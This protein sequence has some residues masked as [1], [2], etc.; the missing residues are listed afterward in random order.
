MT[1]GD[2]K[3]LAK[4]TASDN[5]LRDKAFNILKN[6]KHGGYQRGRNS[7]AYTFFDKKASCS[8]I[9]SMLNQQIAVDLLKPIVKKT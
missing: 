2:F 5:I 8:G 4:K 3:D 9:K 1:Y 7:M 6:P